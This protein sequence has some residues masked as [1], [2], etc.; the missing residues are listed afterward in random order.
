MF[1][2]AAFGWNIVLFILQAA[3]GLG[4][5]IFV[6]ELGHFVVAKLCGVK[7]EKFYIG[8]DVPLKF[9]KLRLPSSLWRKKWGETEYGIGILPLGGYVKMLGQ[10]DNPGRISEEM[11]RSRVAGDA[12]QLGKEIVGP[13]GE[14]YLVDRRSY[15]AK[16]VPQRMAI[17]SAGV[18]MNVIFA[19]IFAAIAYGIGVPYVPCVVSA[20]APGSPAWESNLRIG[21][22]IVQLEDT[23][24][25]TFEDLRS[26]VTLSDLES[27]VSLV[28]QRPGETEPRQLTLKPRK[29]TG[30]AMIGVS[31][32]L[33]L[34][35]DPRYPVLPFSPAAQ[36][37]LVGDGDSENEQQ[38]GFAGGDEIIRVNDTPVENY[39]QFG[40]LLAAAPD[41]PLRVTVRR[42]GKAPPNNPYAARSGG[43]EL[44]FLVQ[45]NP[46][47]RLGI[48]MERGEVAAVQEGSPVADEILE[49]DFIET[50]NGEPFGDPVTWP[51]RVR[52]RALESDPFVKLQVLRREVEDGQDRMVLTPDI[53]PLVPTSL[54]LPPT[55]GAPMS[56][57]SLGIAYRVSN[58]VRDVLPG[59]PAARQGLQVATRLSTSSSLPGTMQKLPTT[60]SRSS[61]LEPT[62]TTKM[63]TT[64]GP[65]F[66]ACCR[67]CRT[68]RRSNSRSSAA[69]AARASGNWNSR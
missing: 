67:T 19:F 45:A 3:I 28:I 39:E 5:V 36:A 27:G 17:I 11:E 66:S 18:V 33:S 49:G 8:F 1:V 34:R 46:M 48:V 50:M 21:D 59:S 16:S 43:K 40:A 60:P 57:P 52:Q 22:E 68:T 63:S 69:R 51:E 23:P 55:K 54:E 13:D 41:Q 14:R 24:N 58:Q 56:C 2:I 10:D 9:G 6:H 62:K 35:L 47:K 65:R 30:L 31:P 26:G 29:G 20:T 32:A 25:P 53:K 12:E 38:A 44:E 64:I 37:K 42:G 7:C 4:A 61:A 15:L